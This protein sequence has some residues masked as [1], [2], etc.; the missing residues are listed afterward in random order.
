MKHHNDTDDIRK[1]LNEHDFFAGLDPG[2]L[3]LL[4]ETGRIERY[5]SGDKIIKKGEH[6]D[7]LYLIT[8]GQVDIIYDDEDEMILQSLGE[9][10]VLGWSWLMP[11]FKWEFD[12][13]CRG[14]VCVISFDAIKL[15]ELCVSNHSAAH[16]FMKRMNHILIQ[17][18]KNL[19]IKIR[20]ELKAVK[21]SE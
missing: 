12:A 10:D 15:R 3:A 21:A 2:S 5:A 6:A 13:I 1:L 19:R 18:L 14:P 11:P 20:E 9:N 17:R 16:E 8:Y 7:F 4:R